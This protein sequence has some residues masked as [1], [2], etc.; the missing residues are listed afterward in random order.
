MS[1]SNNILT[2]FSGVS[3]VTENQIDNA[4]DEVFDA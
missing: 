1:D 2:E 3:V 4:F